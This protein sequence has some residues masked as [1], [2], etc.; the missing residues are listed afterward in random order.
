LKNL[1]TYENYCQQIRHFQR[2]FDITPQRIVCDLHPDYLSTRRAEE[3]AGDWGL[4]L[5][6]VQHH[7]AHMAACMADNGLTEPVIGLVWDGVGYGTDGTAWGGEFLTGDYAGFERRGHLRPLPLPGGDRAVRE[8][9]RLGYA[10]CRDR[11]LYEGF[12]TA[13]VDFLLEKRVNCPLS[14]GMGRLFDAV[15]S[16]TGLRQTVSYEGQGA[17]LLEAAADGSEGRYPI[18]VGGD[19]VF[20][21]APLAAAL[22]EERR[23]GTPVP[24]MAARFMNTLVDMAAEI[25]ERIGAETGIRDVVLSGG[26]FQNMYI[27]ARLPERLRRLGFR[28]FTHSRVSCNDEGLALGQ[29]LIAQAAGEKD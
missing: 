13:G 17:V 21:W 24:V 22:L 10:L 3:L 26:S 18:S 15:C 12:D 25:T 9:W 11:A 4:P 8:I 6:R 16:L 2:L 27:M 5:V 28:V 19:N 1:E 20:D 7:D 23:R 29:L 14:S